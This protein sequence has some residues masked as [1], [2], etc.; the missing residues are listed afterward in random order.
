MNEAFL[1]AL[2]WY[3]RP[4]GVTPPRHRKLVVQK[5]REIQ[6]ALFH[7]AF[8]RARA[9]A[10]DLFFNDE[11]NRMEVGEVLIRVGVFA[12]LQTDEASI[13]FARE[14][15]HN[16]VV[17]FPDDEPHHRAIALCLLGL[18][19]WKFPTLRRNALRQ[20]EYSLA[21]LTDLAYAHEA[22]NPAWYQKI[23]YEISES[24]LM[25]RMLKRF[26]SWKLPPPAQPPAPGASA[27]RSTPTP[28]PKP[29]A[30]P[31]RGIMRSLP[32]YQSVPAGG[33]SAVDPE[34]VQTVQI[35]ELTIDGIRYTAIDLVGNGWVTL[36]EGI[37]YA[38]VRVCGMSMNLL[39][40]EDGD[41]VIIRRQQTANHMDI[42]LVEREDID[43]VA[44][45]KRF[46]QQ[47]NI[48]ELHP[49]S[50]AFDPETDKPYEKFRV[51]NGTQLHILG[52]AIA[53]LKPSRRRVKTPAHLL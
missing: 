34:E 29:K 40:I 41:Y 30:P 26:H 50:N 43:M 8:D 28:P 47:G 23:H 36:Q 31:G 49:V 7:Q 13:A 16:A 24:L 46:Y 33:W 35:D 1:T 5:I 10:K 2:Y 20:W 15:L 53:V 45:L 39:N 37:Q 12:A 21:V 44:T 3:S 9:I 25:T 32:V 6:T 38:V 48:I 51:E 19:Y 17:V 11:L 4:Y 14:Q 27:P 18:I 42:V 52:V 22:A